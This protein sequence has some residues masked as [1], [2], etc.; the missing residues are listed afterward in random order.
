MSGKNRHAKRSAPRASAWIFPWRRSYRLRWSLLLS[1]VIV[2]LIM[3]LLLSTVRVRLFTVPAALNRSAEL[4][5]VPSSIDN[6]E[7]LAQI[8]QKT[9]FPDAS[10]D[11]S[12]EALSAEWLHAELSSGFEPTQE[13][14]SID[15]PTSKPVFEQTWVLPALPIAEA[16]ETVAPTQT[17]HA[18]QPR[19]RWLSPLSASQLPA[20]LP[21][22]VGPAEVVAGMKYLLEVNQE[23][24]VITCVPAGK[25]SDKRI[26]SLENWL[27][28][29]QFPQTKQGLGWIAC[30][31]IWQYDHD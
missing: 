3:A 14:R 21:D 19:P 5:V 31:I 23:G 9:P 30:E 8:A 4:V 13:L 2:L 18:L 17:T 22:Y 11:R 24:R 16:G 27:K 6:Q 25:E 29:L 10:R 7:W 20:R 26:G 28:R 1:A 12:I 15:L